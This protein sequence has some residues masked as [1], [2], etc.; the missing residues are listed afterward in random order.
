MAEMGL[1]DLLLE[2][3]L[4][5]RSVRGWCGMVVTWVDG[6]EDVP[7]GRLAELGGVQVVALVVGDDAGLHAPLGG[8]GVAV[9]VGH[10]LRLL[11]EHVLLLLDFG[12]DADGRLPRSVNE[13]GATACGRTRSSCW[14]RA[15][16]ASCPWRCTRRAACRCSRTVYRSSSPS[17]WPAPCSG[18]G[19]RAQWAPPSPSLGD[20]QHKHS[21]FW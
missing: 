1:C 20:S 7:L 11:E 18:T 8:L 14:T 19:C 2:L 13:T 16:P 6:V 10:L 21:L 15:A 4:W 5:K 3:R 17:W 9:R 12:G